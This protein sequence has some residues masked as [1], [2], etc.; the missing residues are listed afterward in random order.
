MRAQKPYHLSFQIRMQR[1]QTS[2]AIFFFF[3]QVHVAYLE[4][5]CV[6]SDLLLGSGS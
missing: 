3:F 1:T 5:S 2:A 4:L 6:T